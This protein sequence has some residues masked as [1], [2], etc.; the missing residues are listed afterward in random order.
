MAG[1][2][3]GGNMSST[4]FL[5]PR[6]LEGWPELSRQ[7]DQ[8]E[9]WGH[10]K[11]RRKVKSIHK[12]AAAIGRKAL[13]RAVTN[14]GKTIHVRRNGRL[15]GKSGPDY[16]IAS[17]TLKRSIKT[18]DAK[19]SKT[20]VMVGPRSGIIEKRG[21]GAG[22]IRDDGYFA[23]MINEGDLPDFMGGPGSYNGPNR[24]FFERGM[25]PAVM[26]RMLQ[27]LYRGYREAFDNFMKKQ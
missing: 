21:P 19:G 1:K 26:N 9:K 3:A 27:Q 18:F 2:W 4:H 10:S 11:D 5:N 16:D 17:G 24:N 23:H 15:G 8:I 6:K 22:A 14:H 12:K 13:R 7:L 25:S 20:S